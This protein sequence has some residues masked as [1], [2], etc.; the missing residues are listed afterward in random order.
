MTTGVLLLTSNIFHFFLVFLL[1][2][3]KEFCLGLLRLLMLL[4]WHW[5]LKYQHLKLFIL[6]VCG[7]PRYASE[8]IQNLLKHLRWRIFPFICI[9]KPPLVIT[10]V[11]KS[12]KNRLFHDEGHYHIETSPLICTANQWT[13]FDMTGTFAM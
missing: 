1:V 6:D 9:S 7:G 13:G 4:C 10:W 11:T 5:L 12:V 8:H 2:T 3:E